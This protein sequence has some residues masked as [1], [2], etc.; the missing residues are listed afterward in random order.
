MSPPPVTCHKDI[1]EPGVVGTCSTYFSPSVVFCVS[2]HLSDL[3][4]GAERRF[5]LLLL[6][7]VQLGEPLRPQRGAC[8][9]L[10]EDGVH[11]GGLEPARDI[12]QV[13]KAEVCR[14]L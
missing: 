8:Q 9:C 7:L 14:A 3:G 11:R 5:E 6:L 2:S 13:W 10:A 4:R 1:I 12:C